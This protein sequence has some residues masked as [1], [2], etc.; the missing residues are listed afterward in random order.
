LTVGAPPVLF[1]YKTNAQCDVRPT[2][3]DLGAFGYNVAPGATTGAATAITSTSAQL[4]GTVDPISQAVT[5]WFEWGPTAAYGQTS[6]V[7]QL[8]GSGAQAV[9]SPLTGL[10]P[11][12]TFHFNIVASNGPLTTNGTDA[13]FS[14]LNTPPV[15]A[16]DMFAVEPN[17]LLAIP[18][19]AILGNDTDSDGDALTVTN[20][21]APAQ[22]GATTTFGLGMI[23]YQPPANF[24]GTDSF[25]YTITDGFG[26][27]A[28]ATVTVQVK[29]GGGA[30]PKLMGVQA[31]PGNGFTWYYQGTPSTTYNL[32]T[33]TDL[34]TWM[35][36]AAVTTGADGVFGVLQQPGDPVRFYRVK[37]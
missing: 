10:P 19:A 35:P 2:M 33:S 31:G 36:L 7:V 3:L 37:P 1:Q 26:G 25:S 32:Q 21:S 30:M 5:A 20:V 4:N 12:T 11:H 34:I 9:Q 16:P 22:A 28:T 18:V 15:A 24:I 17:T 23:A 6:P 29:P 27:A 8:N 13:V 14:T